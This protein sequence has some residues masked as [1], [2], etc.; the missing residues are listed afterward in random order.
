MAL[1]CALAVTAVGCRTSPQNMKTIYGRHEKP[2]DITGAGMIN[3]NGTNEMIPLNNSDV[4]AGWLPDA[5]KFKAQTVHFA[6]DSSRVKSEDRKKIAVV[7][8]YLKGNPQSAV[9]V[10]GNCDERGTEEYNRALGE[11]RALAA[12]EELIGAG[13]TPERVDTISYGED[14]PVET[15]HNEAAWSKNRRGEFIL[16]HP[17]GPVQ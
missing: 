1:G 4:H 17:K 6:Y 11:R 7:A 13:V 15:G 5:D 16:L 9:R 10:E 12:R 8:D 14:K 2:E 3:P